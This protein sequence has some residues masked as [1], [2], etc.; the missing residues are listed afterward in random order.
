MNVCRLNECRYVSKY[1][2]LRPCMDSMYVDMYVGVCMCLYIYVCI[3]VLMYA[4]MY[5]SKYV[6]TYLCMYV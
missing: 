6:Y 3:N 1:L 4:R 2:R 5:I